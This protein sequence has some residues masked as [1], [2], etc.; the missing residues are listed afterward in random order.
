M[1]DT[2]EAV[3]SQDTPGRQPGSSQTQQPTCGDG[4]HGVRH[5]LPRTACEDMTCTV[6]DP[7]R[8]LLPGPQFPC[9][10]PAALAQGV[11]CLRQSIQAGLACAKALGQVVWWGDR[12]EATEPPQSKVGRGGH[13][14]ER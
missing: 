3:G 10:E 6:P 11:A 4:D 13:R 2:P 8:L 1:V 7:D 14:E 9:R 12:E 5:V